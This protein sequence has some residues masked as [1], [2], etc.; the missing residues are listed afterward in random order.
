VA[1]ELLYRLFD[2]LPIGLVVVDNASGNILRANEAAARLWGY[3]VAECVGLPLLTTI[4]PEDMERVRDFRIRRLRGDPTIP[5][6]YELLMRN[7]HGDRRVVVT[8]IGLIPFDDVIVASLQDVTSERLMLDPMLYNQRSE[9]VSSLAAGVAGEFNSLLA[10]M[11]GYAQ[12]ALARVEGPAESRAALEKVIGAAHKGGELVRSLMSFARR[13]STLLESVDVD[14]TVS[15][16]LE[17]VPRLVGRNVET[18]LHVD[19]PARIVRGDSSQIEQAILNVL[20]NAAESLPDGTGRVDVYVQ[21]TR[22][23]QGTEREPGPETTRGGRGTVQ[24]PGPGAFAVVRVQDNGSGIKVS[25]LPRVFQPFFTTKDDGRHSGLGLPTAQGIINGHGGRLHM[26][27]VWGRG[28]TV[29]IHLQLQEAPSRLVPALVTDGESDRSRK[30]VVVVDD[31]EFVAEL[32]RDLIETAGFSARSFTSS[33]SALEAVRGGKVR[34]DLAIVD[35]MMPGM[36]GVA[37]TRAIR[38]KYPAVQVVALT[39]FKEENMVQGALQAGAMGYLLKN[40][41]AAELSS[42]IRSA[43]ARRMTLSSEAA[44]VLVQASTQSVP[45]AEDLTEREREVLALLVEG[46][47]NG[48]IAERLVVSQSTVKFHIGNIFSK[49]GVDNRVGAVTL[50]LQRKLV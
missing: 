1:R 19:G 4:A 13:G 7:R 45:A 47:N 40:V 10:A 28:T 11:S 36:G 48:E 3:T 18:A 37:A 5:R 12:L 38:Q 42:A 14:Q 21:T 46:L 15:G 34:P 9:A 30:Q 22:E 20:V 6:S 49:L 27:S 50:A 39:S 33:Q 17:L 43:H 23:G 41:S 35:L 16:L 8:H 25:D 2:S 29:T 24:E 31:Q 32:V 44:E 26:E